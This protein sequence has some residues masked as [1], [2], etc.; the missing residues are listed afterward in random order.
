MT[1]NINASV[2]ERKH[3]FGLSPEEGSNLITNNT[4]I[5]TT[6][7]QRL[8]GKAAHAATAERIREE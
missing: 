7:P 1:R 4:I 8:T 2:Q 6:A 5:N 3:H